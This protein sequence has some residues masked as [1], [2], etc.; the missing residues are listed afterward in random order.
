MRFMLQR[1]EKS[2]VQRARKQARA[3]PRMKPHANKT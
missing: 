3:R 2:Q 1:S